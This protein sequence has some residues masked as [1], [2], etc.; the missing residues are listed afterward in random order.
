MFEGDQVSNKLVT[1]TASTT[2]RS[3][4]QH[5]YKKEYPSVPENIFFSGFLLQGRQKA[6]IADIKL[7]FQ[8]VVTKITKITGEGALKTDEQAFT[9]FKAGWQKLRFSLVHLSSVKEE[10]V[11]EFYQTWY[12][13]FFL[14]WKEL[15][16]VND[17]EL[18]HLY[19]VLL[20]FGLYT[21]YKTCRE[22]IKPRIE[23]DTKHYDMLCKA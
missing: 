19:T 9:K 20:I 23:I 8:M 2:G 15:A 12:E 11:N 5:P 17:Q 10:C 21:T 4:L 7:L 6:L 22:Q 1:S 16:L 14:V 3:T 18:K 13:S